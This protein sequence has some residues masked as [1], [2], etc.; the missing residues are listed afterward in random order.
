MFYHSALGILLILITWLGWV[1][2]VGWKTGNIWSYW[3]ARKI[4]RNFVAGDSFSFFIELINSFLYSR[5]LRDQIRYSSAL[6][7]PIFNMWFIGA[8]SFS[9][10]SHQFGLAIGNTAMLL[11]ALIFGNP[12]KIIVYTTTIPGYFYIGLKMFQQITSR[13]W[14]SNPFNKFFTTPLF[15]IYCSSMLVVYIIDT[16][17]GWY[18]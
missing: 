10:E 13:E 5:N 15:L 7:I 16:P 8:L 6:L 2:F 1:L 3:D 18:Y 17:L 12:N 11:I 14:L 9:N 4:A